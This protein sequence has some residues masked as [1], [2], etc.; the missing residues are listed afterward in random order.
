MG[1]VLVAGQLPAGNH[2]NRDLQYLR[3]FGQR[4]Q[5]HGQSSVRLPGEAQVEEPVAIDGSVGE[6]APDLQV[7]LSERRSSDKTV[8]LFDRYTSRVIVLYYFS[9]MDSR[10]TELFPMLSALDEKYRPRG[11][12]IIA[13]T[14][15]K[16]EN[17]EDTVEEHGATFKVE[18]VQQAVLKSWQHALGLLT[19]RI[20]EDRENIQTALRG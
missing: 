10:S 5:D 1:G 18:Q 3:V 16:R 4:P 11:V 19:A 6:P 8:S 14:R 12:A 20:K 15:E 9:S 2:R 7:T 13:L 17:A